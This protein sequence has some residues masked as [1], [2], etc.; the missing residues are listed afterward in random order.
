MGKTA[1]LI[2]IVDIYLDDAWSAIEPL[3]FYFLSFGTSPSYAIIF[4][5][6]SRPLSQDILFSFSNFR[7]SFIWFAPSD[8][9]DQVSIVWPFHPHQFISNDKEKAL[10][11]EI[12]YVRR[13]KNIKFRWREI[14]SAALEKYSWPNFTFLTSPSSQFI[15]NDKKKALRK[16]VDYLAGISA[17][18]QNFSFECLNEVIH[19]LKIAFSA[20]PHILEESFT[21]IIIIVIMIIINL[22]LFIWW[23]PIS[24]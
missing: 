23:S 24:W 6:R 5:C 1:L 11:K 19:E 3:V 18:W 12:D 14:H 20:N 2:S 16:E 10:L 17:A 22:H 9:S 7:S 21:I 13:N 15:S 8:Y 4:T